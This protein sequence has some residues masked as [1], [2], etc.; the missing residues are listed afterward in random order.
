[1]S[2]PPEQPPVLYR[3]STILFLIFVA[4]GVFTIPLIWQSPA[5]SRTEKTFWSIV[6]AA[7]TTL[8]VVLLVV[9]VVMMYRLSFGRVGRDV[10]S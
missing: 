10:L 9:F 7:Y 2:S 3:R 8:A 6:A 4:A 1:M 5:F